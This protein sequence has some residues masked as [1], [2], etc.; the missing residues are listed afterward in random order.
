MA[1]RAKRV[2]RREWTAQDERELRKHAKSRT[3][4]KEN[5][6][7][8]QAHARRFKAK[9]TSSGNPDWASTVSKVAE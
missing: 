5:L 2:V 4:V 3:P 1:K 8:A 6:K 9:S 7:G